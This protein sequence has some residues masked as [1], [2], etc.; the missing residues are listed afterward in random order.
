MRVDGR[1]F[2]QLRDIKITPHVSEYAEG[3]A[4]VEF[5]KTRVLCTASYEPKAPSWLF[6]TGSGWVTAEYG[7][8]P[9][10]TH[11]RMK[12]DKA[13]NS[14]RT[15]EISR[16]IGRSL[17]AAVDLKQLGEKQITV[18]CDVLNADGGTRTAA[19]TGG[20]VALALALKKLHA[21]SEIKALPITHYVSAIS[22]GL[23][24]GKILLDL[25]YDEDSAIGTDMNF[26]MTNAGHFVEV[27]GTAE[28]TPFSKDQ[29][30][31]MMDVADKGCR[32]LFIHQAAI[33]GEIIRLA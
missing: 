33:V 6:G 32:E 17:R 1:Q 24:E 15:Q 13:A 22:V 21:V 3:S 29:L 8:L 30:F 23:H 20:Y 10:S 2:D 25:N 18:D 27:Q 28:H 16:L 11:T 26:V 12:R 31:K 14:G 4:L 7:M 19:V 5:G 9:R